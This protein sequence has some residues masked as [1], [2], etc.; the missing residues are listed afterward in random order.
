MSV[1]PSQSSEVRAGLFPSNTKAAYRMTFPYESRLMDPLSDVLSL[2]KPVS[3]IS[4]GF[5][6]GGDWAVQFA[7]QAK[8]IKCYA[9][10][11]GG[12]WLEVQGLAP[13]RLCAGDSFVLPSGR[14]FKLASNLDITCVPAGDIFPRARA[15]GIVTLNGGG[16]LRL[17]GSRFAVS[18]GQTAMLLSLMPPIVHLRDET[19]TSTLRWAVE[20]MMSEL[21][22]A[23]PGG[24]LIAQH[25]AH[26]ML[27]QALR[28]HLKSAPI[29]GP[30]WFAALADEK[31]GAAI[32]ALHAEP[33]R[34]WTLHT[35]AGQVGMSRSTFALKF[36]QTLGETPMDYLTRW[37]MLLAAERLETTTEPVG[38][39]AFATGYASESAFSTAFRRV[40]GCSPRRYADRG[41]SQG[42]QTEDA[43]AGFASRRPRRMA[44]SASPDGPVD[45]FVHDLM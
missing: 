2:L 22:G 9:V 30:G 32:A 3:Y 19:E 43:G 24:H 26:M 14:P 33:A 36:R 40:M 25:L 12:C 34:R 4:S 16:D 28:L 42:L 41:V 29:D 5:E 21:R 20:R 38:A 15:G 27:V 8:Q 10:T 17:V 6:A 44:A 31:M 7:D 18:G 11:H 37:R 39:I 45:Q 35:L 13:V 23:Q 1:V